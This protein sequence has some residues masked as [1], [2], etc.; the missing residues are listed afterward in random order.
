MD[1]QQ[2]KEGG[3]RGEG[4]GK[5]ISPALFFISFSFFFSIFFPS[6]FHLFF[7]FLFPRVV[8]SKLHTPTVEA[9]QPGRLDA[10][11]EHEPC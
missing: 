11:G 6:S 8:S 4:E 2:N 10:R 9:A 7:G 3:G 5:Q 1:H